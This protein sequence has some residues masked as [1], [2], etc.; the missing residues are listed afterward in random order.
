[1]TGEKV[2]LISGG[3]SGIGLACA[4]LLLKRGWCTIIN[5]RNPERGENALRQLSGLG[6][7]AFVAGDVSIES[8][9][10]D[11]VSAAVAK[12]GRLD[13]LI[14]SAGFYG[15]KL[16]EEI[17][18]EEAKKMFDTNICGTMFLCK[19]ALPEIRKQQGAIVTIGSDAGL[20]GNIACSVYSASKGAVVA[21]TKSLALEEAPHNVRV[22]CV[23]PGDVATPLL[24]RQM[25][26]NPALSE[27]SIKEQYPLYRIAKAEEIANVIAFLLSDEASYVT[28]A[29]WAVDGGLT[30]W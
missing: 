12:F 22:N 2:V 24:E 4:E 17:T 5:G 3:T 14:T 18:Y 10:R 15:E 9:C 25:E 7:A 29:S 6:D 1:M 16:L 11:I 8:G 26:E 23:C 13:G 27:D 21:F 20:Q 19:Y 28:A 30:S